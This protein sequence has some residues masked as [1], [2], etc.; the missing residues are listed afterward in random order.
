MVLGFIYIG[1]LFL[2][3]TPHG[4]CFIL[5]S[6]AMLLCLDLNVYCIFAVNQA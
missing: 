5:K 6:Q 4:V 1:I 2:Q 3:M